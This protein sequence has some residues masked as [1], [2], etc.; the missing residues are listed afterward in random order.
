LSYNSRCAVVEGE[1]MTIGF[2][3]KFIKAFTD[4]HKEGTVDL[5]LADPEFQALFKLSDD[6]LY[7]AAP[8]KLK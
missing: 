4:I 8:L 3:P 7:I 6:Y 5:L 1:P 2:N